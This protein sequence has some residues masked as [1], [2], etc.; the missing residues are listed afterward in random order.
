MFRY[1]TKPQFTIGIFYALITVYSLTLSPKA[2][3]IADTWSSTG[4]LHTARASHT[5]TL[6]NDGRVLVV[7]GDDFGGS[8]P[9]AEVYDPTI[10]T[11]SSTGIL[12]TA[13]SGHT[14]TLLNDGRVLVVG[15]ANSTSS[16]LASAEVYDPTTGT[17]SSTSTL[18]TARGGH[19]ATLL[20]DGRVLVVGGHYSD[21]GYHATAEIYAPITDTWSNT[22]SMSTPRSS[23]TATLLSDGRVL[24]AGGYYDDRNPRYLST[25]EI[26]DPATETWNNTG[27][28][29]NARLSHRGVRMADGRVLVVGGGTVFGYIRS[30]ELYDP[31]T[32]TWSTVGSLLTE[33]WDHSGTLLFDGRVLVTGGDFSRTMPYDELASA[34]AFDP[35]TAV[36]GRTESMNTGRQQHTAT[37][38][39]DGRVLVVGG[40]GNGAWLAS[41]EIF[42]PVK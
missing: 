22:N 39:A 5:A 2:L 28:M 27:T 13:R 32:G 35:T 18:K 7:G 12:K 23:H 29:A 33:R 1:F 19:T 26:Y 31:A 3:A 17:W 24:V 16:Y 42:T 9:S 25:A 34:E 8:L 20:N 14:A 4:G 21:S 37:R 15:G 6:L 38:L 36:W 11:W 30:A 40:Y 10:G 41:A